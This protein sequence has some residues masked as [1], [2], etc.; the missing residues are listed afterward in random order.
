MMGHARFAR[1]DI[2]IP[3]PKAERISVC[4]NLQAGNVLLAN[5]LGHYGFSK[6]EFLEGYKELRIGG[7]FYTY[8]QL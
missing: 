6:E 2:V 7:E 5:V 3:R 1:C 8:N 4:N